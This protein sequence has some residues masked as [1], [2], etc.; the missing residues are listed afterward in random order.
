MLMAQ[1]HVPANLT[2]LASRNLD[3]EAISDMVNEEINI[4]FDD[5]MDLEIVKEVKVRVKIGDKKP[6]SYTVN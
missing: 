1:C 3:E 5:E 6:K 2:L 4:G